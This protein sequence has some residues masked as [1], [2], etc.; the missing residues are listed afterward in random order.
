MVLQ[1]VHPTVARRPGVPAHALPEGMVP[2]LEVGVRLLPAVA[3]VVGA[4]FPE[5]I[6]FVHGVA[7]QVDPVR[8]ALEDAAS[9]L[10]HVDAGVRTGQVRVVTD[11]D[12]PAPGRPDHAGVHVPEPVPLPPLRVA[13]RVVLLGPELES[14]G[15]AGHGDQ[16]LEP[17]AAIDVH[18]VRHRAQPV[19]RVQVAVPDLRVLATPQ[20]LAFVGE[21]D[22][23]QVV[24]VAAL[25][26][27]DL[28]EQ[29][30][31]HHVQHH[32]LRAVVV[33]V[34]HHDAV[35]ARGLGRLHQLPA[36]VE[37][38]GRRDLRGRVLPVL[39][40][41]H[42]DR[43]VPAPGRGREDQVQILLLAH[44]HEVR[45]ATGVERGL[46]LPGLHHPRP[47]TL[48]VSRPDVADGP[49]LDARHVQQ[50][51]HVDRAHAAHAH[52]ADPDH[53][54]GRCG[55]RRNRRNTQVGAFQ[56]G[57]RFAGLPRALGRG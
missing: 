32:H 51:A 53:V 29:P 46:G 40:G 37:G 4:A 30:A 13:L 28:A 43:H 55:E 48:G 45:V 1:V 9:P 19:G 50:V 52:H 54:H 21:L 26:V 49:D 2:L 10:D 47:G 22:G 25:G 39:H 17:V 11:E 14:P 15:W 8:I 3:R 41:R 57:G 20:P 38:G 12:G 5:A 24:Q 33:A 44:T 31:P 56:C 16:R 18:A 27:E 34:L 35:P 6:R 42:A 23:P 36:L 7:F